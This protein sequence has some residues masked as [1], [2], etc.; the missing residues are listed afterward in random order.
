MNTNFRQDKPSTRDWKVSLKLSTAWHFSKMRK[1]AI[2]NLKA[3]S[4]DPAEIY[5]VAR[6]Y[7]VEEWYRPALCELM[8]RRQ[9]LTVQ[10]G[11]K[12]GLTCA[13]IIGGVREGAIIQHRKQRI[14]LLIDGA[15]A[16]QYSVE[17]LYTCPFCQ[18]KIT[19]HWFDKRKSGSAGDKFLRYEV[20]QAFFAEQED[21]KL[22]LYQDSEDGYRSPSRKT[23]K[24][25]VDDGRGNIPSKATTRNQPERTVSPSIASSGATGPVPVPVPVPVPYYADSDGCMSNCCSKLSDACSNCCDAASECCSD[26]CG[27]CS[28]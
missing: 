2:G 14:S 13:V 7:G 5:E 11:R 25:S 9:A 21:D 4:S 20:H 26:C 17:D 6:L 27:C 3:F 12:I 19:E 22:S 28:C 10:D 15:K 24:R 1:Q 23:E 18:A 16:T 8:M